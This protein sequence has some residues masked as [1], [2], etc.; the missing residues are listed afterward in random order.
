MTI[1]VV[2]DGL[3]E[4]ANSV[5]EAASGLMTAAPESRR[6]PAKIHCAIDSGVCLPPSYRDHRL[7][8]RRFRGGDKAWGS[9]Q[10]QGEQRSRPRT[11]CAETDEHLR[12]HPYFS[13]HFSPRW[14]SRSRGG[15]CFHTV[16]PRRL[17]VH[18]NRRAEHLHTCRRMR[19]ACAH[20]DVHSSAVSP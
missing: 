1:D 8:S 16:C 9:A 6:P 15:A 7:I 5:D 3:T 10:S 13:F 11:P 17:S 2:E 18:T 20:A 12:G 4:G 19:N 14:R